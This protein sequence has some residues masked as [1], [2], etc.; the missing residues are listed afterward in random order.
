[1][2]EG[3]RGRTRPWEQAG[4][5]ATTWDV[6]GTKPSCHLQLVASIRPLHLGFIFLHLLDDSAASFSSGQRMWVVQGESL[7]LGKP[8]KDRGHFMGAHG[9][10]APDLAAARA[11]GSKIQLL[12]IPKYLLDFLTSHF[13]AL[14]AETRESGGTKFST[15]LF[16][17]IYY[18]FL[19]HPHKP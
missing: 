3:G 19:L 2:E 9:P 15:E 13:D 14:H 7:L 5:R 4:D 12:K 16:F 8:R 17:F 1:M 6:P 10:R 11:P 18:F